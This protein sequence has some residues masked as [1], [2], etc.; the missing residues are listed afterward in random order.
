M[1]RSSGSV[2]REL[3]LA[4]RSSHTSFIQPG[5]ATW[6]SWTPYAQRI[7]WARLMLRMI[8]L[9]GAGWM[10]VLPRWP[11]RIEATSNAACAK[12]WPEAR[13]NRAKMLRI[14][15]TDLQ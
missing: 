5:P 10:E 6:Y 13:K 15:E 2:A 8:R 12:M 4:E 14:I 3:A 1:V 7:Q 9:S 11:T